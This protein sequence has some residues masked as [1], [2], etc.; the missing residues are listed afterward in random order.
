MKCEI[1]RN[2]FFYS[3]S[4]EDKAL[5]ERYFK[6]PVKCNGVIV[7]IGA[8]DGYSTSISKIFED[9]LQWDSILVEAKPKNF[10][11]LIKNRLKSIKYYATICNSEMVHF[12]RPDTVD[13]VT[14]SMFERRKKGVRGV[15]LPCSRLETLLRN[16]T[17]IDIFVLDVDGGELE[18]LQTMDWTKT[19][20][21]WVVKLDGTNPQ[22]DQAVR[23]LLISKG[24]MKSVWDMRS[25]CIK[26]TY[27]SS[28]EVF[29]GRNCN[30]RVVSYSLFGNNRRYADGAIANAELMVKI[31]PE[32][33]MYVYFDN[34]VPLGIIQQLTQYKSISL[35]NM[36]GSPINNKMSWRFLVAADTDV[37]RYVVRDI[38]SR[39]SLREK[40]AV[41]EWI[42]SQKKFHVMRDH[43]SHS[44]YTM[45]GGMWG[46]TRD[47][48]PN[49]N[50]LLIQKTMSNVYI[51]DMNF[52]DSVVWNIARQSILQ[53]DSF[54]CG[55]FGDDH[56]FP[57][58]RVG[59][60]HVGSVYIDGRMRQIDVDILKNET[61]KSRKC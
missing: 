6:Y 15:P 18:A 56:P 38:D 35:I 46:G 57:S 32:W 12:R 28:S 48:L 11:A 23:N 45:S 1:P 55:R 50:L 43:P 36:T 31:Y 40:A 9:Q 58:K 30:K 10:R 53:H 19:V 41:D 17:H 24:Y 16:V 42:E 61:L 51:E 14:I 54:S 25:V 39:L 22:K 29:C 37:E 49:I 21:Y 7:E 33:T 52:L 26:R 59:F 60:E 20:D 27:C 5:Y 13:G 44:H 34:S 8:S 2:T 3:Q 47:A 4:G